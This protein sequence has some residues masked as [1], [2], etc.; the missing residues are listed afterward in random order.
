M[1]TERPGIHSSVGA[2]TVPPGPASPPNWKRRRW[3][4][5][6]VATIAIVCGLFQACRSS[7]QPANAKGGAAG[8]RAV[9]VVA[10]PSRT[11]D[12]GVYQTG[13]GTVTPLK[14]VT[15]RSRVD[16]QLLSVGYREGQVVHEGD[17][18]AQIDPRPFEVQL[19]EAQGQLAK[20]EAAL[21]NAQVDLE[22]YKVLVEQDSIARQ[23]L[24]A[25]AAT[26]RQN[27]AT[28]KSDQAQVESA[29]LNLTYS[30][31]TAPISGVVGLRLVDPGNM[32][33]AADPAGLLVITQEQPIA[34]LFTIPADRLPAVLRQTKA[35]RT[36]T[37]EAWDRNLTHKLAT[38]SLSAI[39]NQIDQATGTVRIKA[40]FPN[41]DAALY[42]N[43]FV[44]ARLLVDTLRNVVLIPT[45]ALEQSPKST[46]VYVVKP[47]STVE[48]REVAVQLTAGDDT[49]L[50]HGIAAGEMVVVD[51]MDKLQS[52]M[53]VALAGANEGRKPSR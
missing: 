34:T 28:L 50:S 25:Q 41:Q 7:G 36:L 8:A 6:A 40:L 27:Q 32:V 16:G 38:G 31:I 11:G 19:H 49:A 1:N 5:W 39:D 15:V 37:V 48:T 4:Y 52:G 24:D 3:W 33:H 53:K 23:Q 35:G 12:L 17:L 22:R 10:L 21:E 2:K 46:Y 29:N 51:G 18:L 30:R 43:Q 9:P 13:L 47:D 44:N 26:V 14:T 20:D 42:P 45:A